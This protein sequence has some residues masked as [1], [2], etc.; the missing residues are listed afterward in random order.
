[1]AGPLRLKP[2]ALEWRRVEDEIVALD[3]AGARYVG[4]NPTGAVL[5]EALSTG[6][7]ERELA[8]TLEREYD[9]SSEQAL[10][11]VRAFVGSLDELGLLEAR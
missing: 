9:L 1:M 7:D 6:A 2:E 4:V 10:A 8:A 3:S 5:W 11:D